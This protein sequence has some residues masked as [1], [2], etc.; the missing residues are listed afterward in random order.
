MSLV[1]WNGK[2]LL[3]P[4]G[5]LTTGPAGDACC[6]V[7]DTGCCGR[8]QPGPTSEV[9]A[10]YYPLTLHCRITKADGCVYP[11]PAVE[12]DAEWDPG[13]LEWVA[14][15]INLGGSGGLALLRFACTGTLE[16]NAGFEWGVCTINGAPVL[17]NLIPTLTN[18]ECNPVD[19]EA[20]TPHMVGLMCCGSLGGG[21]LF[22]EVWE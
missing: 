20:T 3:S 5:R 12:F 6:C 16:W 8:L 13:E 14:S 10:E 21:H 22:I 19:L 9:G 7:E 18:G 17:F 4:N 1:T 2:L 11:D 15:D